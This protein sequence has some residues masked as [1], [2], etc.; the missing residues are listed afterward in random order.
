RPRHEIRPAS[1]EALSVGPAHLPSVGFLCHPGSN[2]SLPPARPGSPRT[3][4]PGRRKAVTGTDRG[5]AR[6]LQTPTSGPGTLRPAF[7][8]ARPLAA[9]ARGGV[10]VTEATLSPPATPPPAEGADVGKW[11]GGARRVCG[12][13]RSGAEDLLDWLEVHRRRGWV[14]EV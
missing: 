1:G 2:P 6:Q 4:T 9:R 13:S 3:R 12:L 5:P 8:L 10:T 7:A 11:G 14:L